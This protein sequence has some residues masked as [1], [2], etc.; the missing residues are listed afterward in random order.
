MEQ[1]VTDIA[2]LIPSLIEGSGGHRTI[3]H[4]ASS[5]EQKGYS[6][7]IYLEGSGSPSKAS[8]IVERQ[9]GYKFK[10]VRYGWSA[11]DP[12][13]IVI[14]TIWYSAIIVRDLPFDCIR[15]YFVQDYEAI[16]N[17]V[18]D[19]YILAENS[20]RY[21]L[22]P[23]T[24]GRWLKQELGKR[25]QIPAYHFNFGAD[26]KIYRVLSGHRREQAVCFIYQPDKPRRCSRIG[27]AALG[28]VKYYRPDVTIYLYGSL[29]SEKSDIWFEHRHL[30]LL[31]LEACNNLYNR[32]AV[33]LCLSSSN[34]SRIPFEMMA[35][36]LP[37]VELWREN[38]LY[39]F[40]PE[41]VSLSD[42]TPESL[43]EAILQL[44]NSSEER[45]RMSRA[46]VAYMASHTL[47]SETDAFANIMFSLQSKRFPI[48]EILSPLYNKPPVVA[49]TKYKTLP[50][51]IRNRIYQPINTRL[52]NLPQPVRKILRWGYLKASKALI[53]K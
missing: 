47:Q 21:G 46:G 20:Y 24:I 43:A 28:L 18:G 48:L 31:N 41:A 52:N 19:S 26:N 1:I 17:P 13:D 5:L 29:Q 34:P 53:V 50:E 36:G 35:A 49:V 45:D 30:G 10:S 9:F 11:I 15:C 2:W 33:G 32:C 51:A 6:C 44:L 3:L 4:H 38:N 27:I 7:H 37:V 25:F 12:A 42:Q 8:K 40:P 16:F 39:D 23:I 14:A 22:V